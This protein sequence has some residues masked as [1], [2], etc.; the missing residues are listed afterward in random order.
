M[1]PFRGLRSRWMALRMVSIGER[2][3]IRKQMRIELAL[4]TATKSGA[5]PL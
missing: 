2:P 4:E 3:P 5:M 1:E